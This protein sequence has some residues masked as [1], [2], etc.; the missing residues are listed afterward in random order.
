MRPS[1]QTLGVRSTLL[2]VSDTLAGLFFS[3]S[4]I[5]FTRMLRSSAGSHPAVLGLSLSKKKAP[6]PNN[7]V[8]R[9]CIKK[10]H[11]QADNPHWPLVKVDKIQPESG[12]PRTPESGIAAMKSASTRPRRTV[13]NQ[14]LR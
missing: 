6:I 1:I 10:S 12:P 11:C 2:N 13:G 9:P 3:S 8:G 4:E 14:V 7:T 5:A